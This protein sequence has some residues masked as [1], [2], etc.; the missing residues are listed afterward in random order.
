MVPFATA[1][2]WA[3]ATIVYS[4][5]PIIIGAADGNPSILFFI[6]AGATLVCFVINALLMVETKGLNK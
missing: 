1:D 3:S 6:F 5:T 2:N 4:M